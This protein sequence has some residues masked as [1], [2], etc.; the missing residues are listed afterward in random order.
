MLPSAAIR[1]RSEGSALTSQ[2][3]DARGLRQN[4]RLYRGWR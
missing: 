2:Q 1:D 3:K 4:R